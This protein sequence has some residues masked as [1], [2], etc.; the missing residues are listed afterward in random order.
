MILAELAIVVLLQ[1]GERVFIDVLGKTTAAK[2][3][4]QHVARSLKVYAE[5]AKTAM[6]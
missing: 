4:L 6:T 2:Q 5:E 1:T 3:A